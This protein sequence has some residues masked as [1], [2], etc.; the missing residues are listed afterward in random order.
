MNAGFMPDIM[1]IVAYVGRQLY[2][3]LYR[4]P[5]VFSAGAHGLCL[6]DACDVSARLWTRGAL[7]WSIAFQAALQVRSSVLQS[8]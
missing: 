1:H 8:V 7:K 4:M 6:S 2:G 5:S 3:G